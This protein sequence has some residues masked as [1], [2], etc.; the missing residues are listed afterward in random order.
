[1][2]HLSR[3]HALFLKGVCNGDCL[4]IYSFIFFLLDS[5]YISQYA[6]FSNAIRKIHTDS[7]DFTLY[8]S[9]LGVRSLEFI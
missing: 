1:M 7:K 9:L 5:V 2:E 4:F 6:N 3:F 8:L